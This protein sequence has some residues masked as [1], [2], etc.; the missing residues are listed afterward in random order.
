[1]PIV[2]RP[3]PESSS[4]YDLEH[5]TGQCRFKACLSLGLEEIPAFVFPMS[6]EEAIQRSW[7][8][9]EARGDLTYSDRAYWTERI[10][11]QYSGDGH[12]AQE[13]LEMAADYL[14]VTTQTVMRYYRLVALP[15]GLKEMVDQGILPSGAAGE[16]VRN[17]YD[18]AQV[19]E[20]QQ[21]MT[22]RASWFLGLD[23]DAREHGIKS[24]QDLG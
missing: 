9:N 12:T 18:G 15:E 14:G 3:H 19:E 6:D 24:L 13:A 8:E 17:T 22:E 21:A 5:V 23:R 10:F 1:M 4:E 20:S 11:K 16:I 2:V 7:L